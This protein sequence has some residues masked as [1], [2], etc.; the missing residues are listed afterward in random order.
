M[1]RHSQARHHC[2]ADCTLGGEHGRSLREEETPVRESMHGMWRQRMG[3]S[4]DAHRGWLSWLHRSNNN[5]IPDQ[6]WTNK[7][8]QTE[9]HTAASNSSGKGIQ[10]DLVQSQKEHHS[11][12]K[13]PS[14]LSPSLPTPQPTPTPSFPHPLPPPITSIPIPSSAYRASRSTC[15]P[16]WHHS[17]AEAAGGARVW[18]TTGSRRN[19]L[20][21]S[22]WWLTRVMSRQ[23]LLHVVCIYSTG[24][25]SRKYPCL[26]AC[27]NDVSLCVSMFNWKQISHTSLSKMCFHYNFHSC[28]DSK[29][30]AAHMG[31]TWV[32]SAPGGPHVSPM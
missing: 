19:H 5:L 28:P 11:M 16:Q 18:G 2:G 17:V 14:F 9:G 15:S 1:V 4:S 22:G 13:S 30:N 31:P 7:Q 8:G 12:T 10:L 23:L 29:V 25:N 21:C 24:Y 6:A 3:L 20:T 27:T 32:L 26:P